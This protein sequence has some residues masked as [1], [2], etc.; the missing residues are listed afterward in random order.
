MK[1]EYGN[2]YV[3]GLPP[4]C[5]VNTTAQ[6]EL[7]GIYWV[8]TLKLAA[9][10]DIGLEF[11]RARFG[12]APHRMRIPL[13]RDPEDKDADVVYQE[14]T[15]LLY[16]TGKLV[17]TGTDI[18]AMI[19]YGAWLYANMLSEKTGICIYPAKIRIENMVCN[20]YIGFEID[21]NAFAAA[22]SAMC[23]YD[24]KKFPAVVYK[25]KTKKNP[26]FTALV[27]FTGRIIITGSRDENDSIELFKS[28][29]KKLIHYKADEEMKPSHILDPNSRLMM[30]V[31]PEY[32]KHTRD[33]ESYRAGHAIL[34]NIRNG[35]DDVDLDMLENT[36]PE[37]MIGNLRSDEL[38]YE[39]YLSEQDM[40][41]A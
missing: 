24:H 30:P 6:L 21:L 18:P 29:Y 27:N 7:A 16:H 20:Y 15:F 9:V 37:L 28:L 33:I 38:L 13:P 41:D 12:A 40:S 8:N 31:A 26:K 14:I 36:A 25:E 1:D 10:Y 23:S 11:N 2:P 32:I 19:C 22:E 17:L 35:F 3:E 4:G 39:Q 34:K 5:I